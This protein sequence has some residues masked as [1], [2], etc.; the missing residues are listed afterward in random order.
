MFSINYKGRYSADQKKL[1]RQRAERAAS[2][3]SLPSQQ[4]RD[5]RSAGAGDAGASPEAPDR[6][7]RAQREMSAVNAPAAADT[8]SLASQ[9]QRDFRPAGAGDAG[10]SPAAPDRRS[11]PKS[12]NIS[13]QT[14][15]IDSM[16]S[17]KRTASDLDDANGFRKYARVPVQYPPPGTP[18][19]LRDAEQG[20]PSSVFECGWSRRSAVPQHQPPE[21]LTTFDGV[22]V[23]GGIPTR[24]SAPSS[25]LRTPQP[26]APPPRRYSSHM[27]AD[28]HMAVRLR[29]FNDEAG[30]ENAQAQ[31]QADPQIRSQTQASGSEPIPTG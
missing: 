17:R 18:P 27:P 15:N 23:R 25:S 14:M 8:P 24:P 30:R 28:E 31:V 7:S 9:E 10:A 21:T 11:I 3:S 29:E 20:R 4:Q 1:R 16:D 26:A 5:F 2:T 19:S 13:E 6:R 22:P 12:S